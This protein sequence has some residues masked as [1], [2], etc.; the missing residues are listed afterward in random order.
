MAVE[1]RF[2]DDDIIRIPVFAPDNAGKPTGEKL[3]TFT[4]MWG[5]QVRVT[6]KQDDRL[7][8]EFSPRE[9]DEENQRY[10]VVKYAG[11]LPKKAKFRD[12]S[13]LKV[14]FVDVGQG[15]G[16]MVETPQGRILFIDGGE[17]EHLRRYVNVAYSHLLR[18]KPLHCDALIVTH[19]DADH[20]EGLTRLVRAFRSKEDPM[21][22]A[23]RVFHNGLVKKKKEEG[24]PETVMFGKTAT[25]DGQT[26]AV[27]LEDDLTSG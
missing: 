16:A 15:D 1:T 22:T 20:F 24:T 6:G 12:A 10:E 18:T 4:L 17:E 14:R 3:K 26:Y 9:W 11:L 8:V 27:E 2:L 13:V 25:V 19:G 23:D 21:I 5:D 7:V